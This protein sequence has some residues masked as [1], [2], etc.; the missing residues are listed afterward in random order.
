MCLLPA[1]RGGF[2]SQQIS[3]VFRGYPLITP[4]SGLLLLEKI[5]TSSS[6]LLNIECTINE[7][8]LLFPG[9]GKSK[10]AA[11]LA[12]KYGNHTV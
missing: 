11:K 12:A 9:S 6:S 10:K 4:K 5:P 1:G 8:I 3:G 2:S 7:C